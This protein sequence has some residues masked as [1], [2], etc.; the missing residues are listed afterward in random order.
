[1]APCHS[2]NF[3]K[4]GRVVVG[5]DKNIPVVKCNALHVGKPC[6]RHSVCPRICKRVEFDNDSWFSGRGVKNAADAICGGGGK[7]ILIRAS[8]RGRKLNDVRG[9]QINEHY[10]EEE[11]SKN[12]K[13]F[14][15]FF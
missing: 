15:F 8:I 9:N 11:Q 5:A 7:L 3:C 4:L 12:P 13:H 6:K 2:R 1:M 14:L 10:R